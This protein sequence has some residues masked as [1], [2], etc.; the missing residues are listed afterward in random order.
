MLKTGKHLWHGRCYIEANGLRALID[1]GLENTGHLTL[2]DIGLEAME[3]LLALPH[4]PGCN[5]DDCFYMRR[6]PGEGAQ[7]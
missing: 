3:K 7:R 5:C 2:D 1:Q 6:A 4:R